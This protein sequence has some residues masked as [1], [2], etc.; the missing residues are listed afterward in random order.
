MKQ[1]GISGLF[2]CRLFLKSLI[3]EREVVIRTVV[4]RVDILAHGN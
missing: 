1:A 2:H 3:L 4:D